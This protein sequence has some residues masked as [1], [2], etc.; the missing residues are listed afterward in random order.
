MSQGWEYF[1]EFFS[2]SYNDASELSIKS[3]ILNYKKK[4]TENKR[5][6][7]LTEEFFNCTTIGRL[8]LNE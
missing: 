8:Q 6:F 2:A 5:T 7:F 3:F 1:I 4:K